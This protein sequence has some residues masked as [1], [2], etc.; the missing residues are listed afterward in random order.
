[1]LAQGDD[2]KAE[3]VA[4]TEEGAKKGEESKKK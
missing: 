4:A 2:L 1:L 3:I